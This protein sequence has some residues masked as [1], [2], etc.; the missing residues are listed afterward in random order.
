MIQKHSCSP[1]KGVRHPESLGMILISVLQ[2]FLN[3]FYSRNSVY[4]KNGSENEMSAHFRTCV[5]SPVCD[6]N[7]L[8][9]ADSGQDLVCSFTQTSYLKHTSQR[10]YHSQVPMQ[11]NH[12]VIS[13]THNTLQHSFLG[14]INFEIYS[15]YYKLLLRWSSRSAFTIPK[16]NSSRH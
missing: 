12:C 7:R 1:E 4:L 15:F 14:Y 11:Q 9:N 5:V 3:R 10:L 8:R 13:Q 2:V 16:Q 6:S